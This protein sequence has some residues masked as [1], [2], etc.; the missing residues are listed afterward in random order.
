MGKR[1]APKT[2]KTSAPAADDRGGSRVSRPQWT[3][4]A[5]AWLAVHFSG[6]KKILPIILS[7]VAVLVILLVIYLATPPAQSQRPPTGPSEPQA[8][9]EIDTTT[10]PGGIAFS[11]TPADTTT[12]APLVRKDNFYTFLLLGTH[13]DYNTDTIMLASMDLSGDAPVVNVIS[14]PRDSQIDTSWSL[15]KINSVYGVN[16]GGEEG[17]LATCEWIERITG[18]WPDFYAVVNIKSF[19]KLVDRVGGVPFYIPYDMVHTKPDKDPEQAYYINMPKGQYNL[20]S[21]QALAVVRYRGTGRS[22]WGR[23][24]I[25]KDFMVALL[26]QVKRSFTLD[27]IPG[28]IDVVVTSLKTNM[29]AK[30][31]LWFYTNGVAKMDLKE[32]IAMHNLPDLGPGKYNGQDYVFLDAEGIAKLVSET[33]N[34]YTTPIEAENLDIVRLEN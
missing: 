18:V 21:E 29:G 11:T 9:V 1:E 6:R 24:D 32:N 25:Q 7:T 33:I 19:T 34:P 16:K 3:A 30:D 13:D 17:A 27:K 8:G 4:R 2:K 14:I 26:Q 20:S 12:E 5:G 23:M 31:M 28:M 15:K 10:L 22:D